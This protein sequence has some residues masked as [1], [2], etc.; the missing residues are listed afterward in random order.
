MKKAIV[1]LSVITVIGLT[2]CSRAEVEKK[3]VV[4]KDVVSLDDEKN[5]ET[6]KKASTAEEVTKV[7]E[8]ANSEIED[9]N[10]DQAEKPTTL[11]IKIE[12]MEEKINGLWHTGDGY[13]IVY[14]A[15]RFEYSD[16]DGVD[17]FIADNSDPAIYPYVYLCINHLKDKSATDYVKKLSDTLSANGFKSEIT[18]D[19]TIGNYK[20]TILTA[21]AGSEWNSIIRNYY[22]IENGTSIYVIEAQYF[23]EASEGYGARF[24]AMLNTFKMK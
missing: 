9:D 5:P 4:V 3:P 17:N 8:A 12:G 14:D 2:G 15:D 7:S 21:Q 20:G 16:K 13:E 18:T 23:V 22:I 1:I 11:T 19:A 6:S 24:E 10:S